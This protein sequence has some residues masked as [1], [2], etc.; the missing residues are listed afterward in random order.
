[1]EGTPTSPGPQ[2]RSSTEQ[3]PASQPERPEKFEKKSSPWAQVARY[4]AIGMTIPSH[5]FA[6][7]L[8]GTILDRVF[9]TTYLYIVLV[10]VG[11]VSGF[12]EMIRLAS[13]NLD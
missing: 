4:S 13:K 5:L 1:M 3:G 7:W 2:K 10:L 9:S 12:V 6:G 8:L 11:A